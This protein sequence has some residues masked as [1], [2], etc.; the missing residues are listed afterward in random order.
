[1]AYGKL[2]V[3]VGPMF[4]G[5]TEGLVKEVLFMTYFQDQ[6]V[7]HDRQVGI[8][9]TSLDTRFDDAHIV[10]HNGATLAARSVR[11]SSDI[12]I[13]SLSAAFFDEVQF[14][15]KPHFDGDLIGIVRELRARGID[16]YCAGL[17]MDYLGHAFE[18]TSVLMAEASDLHRMTAI[19][20]T[21]GAPATHT[22][23]ME[24]TAERILLGARDTYA[25]MCSA[26]W[27][28]NKSRLS[29]PSP[30]EAQH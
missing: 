4:A 25:P 24:I 16:V 14:F 9:K 12:D 3:F 27:H 8:F 28:E 1:M 22:T 13:A 18:V 29:E 21:C 5:K 17:D 10:S 23:S 30:H 7:E 20:T 19:C 11:S 6:V 26:H 2:H 15:S